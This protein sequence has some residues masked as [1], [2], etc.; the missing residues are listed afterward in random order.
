MAFSRRDD[1][2]S[3]GDDEGK[4]SARPAADANA[5]GLHRLGYA[6]MVYPL[7]DESEVVTEIR[8]NPLLAAELASASARSSDAADRIFANEQELPTTRSSTTRCPRS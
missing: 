3:G 2:A 7:Y 1:E 6:R 5:S 4:R 8:D